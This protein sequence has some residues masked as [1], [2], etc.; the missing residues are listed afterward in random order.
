MPAQKQH[1]KIGVPDAES[2]GAPRKQRREAVFLL[3]QPWCRHV[4]SPSPQS[5]CR[6]TTAF[7]KYSGLMQLLAVGCFSVKLCRWGVF[8]WSFLFVLWWV[9]FL[10][11]FV[12]FCC[13]SCKTEGENAPPLIHSPDAPNDQ[14]WAGTIPKIWEVDPGLP[15]GGQEPNFF[16]F[17]CCLPG[18]L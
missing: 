17:T 13:F 9:C 18:C 10:F 4:A 2:S 8:T 15:R 12:I 11:C 5:G 16:S 14:G 3:F 6:E 7:L 1:F